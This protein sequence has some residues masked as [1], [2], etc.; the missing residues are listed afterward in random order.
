MEDYE[1]ID[2]TSLPLESINYDGLKTVEPTEQD[3]EKFRLLVLS[4]QIQK[5]I[6]EESEEHYT[7]FTVKQQEDY[8]WFLTLNETSN[9][10]I[11]IKDREILFRADSYDETLFHAMNILNL[12][13]GDFLII[14]IQK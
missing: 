5:R 6:W 7:G 13:V 14:E 12:P 2:M 1:K 9:G 4:T 8:D 11:L 3:M 10:C